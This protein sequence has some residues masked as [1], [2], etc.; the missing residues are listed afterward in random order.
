MPRPSLLLTSQFCVPSRQLHLP[1]TCWKLHE[2][3]HEKELVRWTCVRSENCSKSTAIDRGLLTSEL[4][5]F[6]WRLLAFVWCGGMHN[7]KCHGACS[8]PRLPASSPRNR[9]KGSCRH[10]GFQASSHIS[11]LNYNEKF[12]R[13]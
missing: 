7:V 11:F 10:R 3:D 2:I 13:W 12:K 5:P 4:R 9:N 6:W 8:G 1:A